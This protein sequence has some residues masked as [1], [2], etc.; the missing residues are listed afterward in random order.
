M[1]TLNAKPEP[2]DVD[3]RRSAVVVV[4][5][6]NAFATKGGMLDIAGADISQD[7]GSNR[8]PDCLPPGHV[9]CRLSRDQ[10][11]FVAHAV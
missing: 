1:T 8:R 7:G 3:L 9:E 2:V 4:D 11:A 5:M 10:D 6:Q